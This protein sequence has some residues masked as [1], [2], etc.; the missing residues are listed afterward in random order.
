MSRVNII[1]ISVGYYD[2]GVLHVTVYVSV[3]SSSSIATFWSQLV[4]L[5][6]LVPKQVTVT[7]DIELCA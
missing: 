4:M 2:A 1:I 7:H 6:L 3:T 5:R